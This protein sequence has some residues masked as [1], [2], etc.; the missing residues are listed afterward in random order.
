MARR[1]SV[2]PNIA[3]GKSIKVSI[4]GNIYIFMGLFTNLGSAIPQAD[5]K[6]RH[7]P[8]SGR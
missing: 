5:I 8:V 3:P 1:A 6:A 2:T 7:P 4:L